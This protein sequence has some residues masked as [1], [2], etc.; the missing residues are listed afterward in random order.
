MYITPHSFLMSTVEIINISENVLFIALQHYLHI[1]G[2]SSG[3]KPECWL[4]CSMWCLCFLLIYVQDGFLFVFALWQTGDVS[5][6]PRPWK[7]T[8]CGRW[9][10]KWA[11]FCTWFTGNTDIFF[12]QHRT[13]LT[14]QLSQHIARQNDWSDLQR[15]T[16]L[17]SRKENYISW[18]NNSAL[19]LIRPFVME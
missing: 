16:L 3:F 10:D 1:W 4:H 2:R 12:Q 7:D 18:T 9:M 14:C 15:R 19:V 11:I 6:A 17:A 5:G 13:K 8:Q